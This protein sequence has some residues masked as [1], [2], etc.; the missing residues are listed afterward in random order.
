M[1]GLNRQRGATPFSSRG[2]KPTSVRVTMTSVA[3]AAGVSIMTVSRALRNNPRLPL[4]TRQR[5]QAIAKKLGYRPDPTVSQL[6]ARL[7]SSRTKDPETLAWLNP[8]PLRP[9]WRDAFASEEFFQGASDRAAQLGYKLDVI[10]GHE[11]GLTSRRL[12]R[13]LQTRSIVGVLIAPLPGIPETVPLEWNC[14]AAATYGYTVLEPPLHRACNHHPRIIRRGLSEAIARGYRRPG[15]MISKTDNLRVDE[16]WTAGFLSFQLHLPA[17]DHVPVLLYD[18]NDMELT[19]R[20]LDRHAPDVVFA[21]ATDNL[22]AIRATGRR[23]PDDIGFI[24]LDL[25]RHTT[26]CAG[27]RQNHPVVGAAAVDL[28]VAQLHRGERGIPKVPKLLLVEGEW[29]D[30]PTIRPGRAE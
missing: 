14:F 4:K 26:H 27:M 13:I 22:K 18:Q 15:L 29:V 30:G 3:E 11:P 9:D 28:V 5:I 2:V 1:A 20:W 16:G 6:M 23:V 17:S 12:T 19:A 24:H 21:H 8:R 25:D 7:R 10:S